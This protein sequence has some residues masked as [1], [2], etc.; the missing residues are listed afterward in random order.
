MAAIVP[1]SGSYELQS[2]YPPGSLKYSLLVSSSAEFTQSE[3]GFLDRVAAF[4]KISLR[5]SL[6]QGIR[7]RFVR[8]RAVGA[9]IQERFGLF[10]AGFRV[11][12]MI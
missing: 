4:F 5:N 6:L 7:W 12:A 10:H 8:R 9:R 1:Q 11:I 3:A 2:I